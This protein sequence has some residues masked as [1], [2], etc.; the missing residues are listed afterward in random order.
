MCV[1]ICVCVCI[2][3]WEKENISA[4][5]KTEGEKTILHQQ[6]SSHCVF[7]LFF[8][9]F[10]FFPLCVHWSWNSIVGQWVGIPVDQLSFLTGYH[11]VWDSFHFLFLITPSLC[12]S[13]ANTSFESWLFLWTEIS[14]S[15]LSSDIS[16]FHYAGFC[17]CCL[18]G[19]LLILQYV[20]FM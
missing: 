9:L 1:F 18:L 15:A 6:L 20:F 14:P 10:S 3:L 4:S 16:M 8:H 11:L 19:F 12:Y 5:L 7:N 17:P 2:Y 13:Q